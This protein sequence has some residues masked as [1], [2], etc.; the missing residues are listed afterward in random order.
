MST[1]GTAGDGPRRDDKVAGHPPP[2]QRTE[3]RTAP[4][5]APFH[6]TR[7]SGRLG[8]HQISVR[9]A[10]SELTVAGEGVAQDLAEAE[11]QRQT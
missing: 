1:R 5:P 10:I 9:R 3:E 11:E 6:S 8:F 2:W 4:D 7:S